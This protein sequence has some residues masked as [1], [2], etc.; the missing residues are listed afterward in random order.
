[1][2][3]LFARRALKDFKVPR[4][5]VAV[6]RAHLGV[7]TEVVQRLGAHLL[8]GKPE[9]IVPWMERLDRGEAALETWTRTAG[10]GANGAGLPDLDGLV[11]PISVQRGRK[12]VPVDE[13][14]GFKPGDR[15]QAAVDMER[16]QEIAARLREAGWEPA[17]PDGLPA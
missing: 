3:L 17:G 13:S 16:R 2:N 14:L 11:L 1:V 15:L 12:C 10:P 9:E 4:V 8:F 7:D 5:W 6:R